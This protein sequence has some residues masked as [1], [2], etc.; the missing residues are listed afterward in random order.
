MIQLVNSKSV[1]MTLGPLKQNIKTANLHFIA[2]LTQ[3]ILTGSRNAACLP[4][5]SQ[6]SNLN[7]I[8]SYFRSYYPFKAKF[9]HKWS[10]FSTNIHVEASEIGPKLDLAR[11]DLNNEINLGILMPSLNSI[12]TAI[13]KCDILEEFGIKI[14]VRP[15]QYI[16]PASNKSKGSFV[17]LTSI[18]DQKA[19]RFGMYIDPSDP[20]L[21]ESIRQIKEL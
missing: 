4:Q 8:G 2:L 13:L 14:S 7:S 20:N 17:A 16:A 3:P 6:Y 21:V 5:L 10:N 1:E 11:G 19:S 12:D 15:Q 18:R 9:D